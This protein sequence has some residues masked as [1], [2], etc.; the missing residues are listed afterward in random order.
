MT[1]KF[2]NPTVEYNGVTYQ[3][4]LATVDTTHIG[5]EDHGIFSLNLGFAYESGSYQGIGHLSAG[6]EGEY[7]G[8]L[9]TSIL[10]VFGGYT[11]WEALKGS[12]IYVLREEGWNGLIRGILSLDQE[13][14]LVFSDLFP[15]S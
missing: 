13:R 15:N 6:K 1:V 4:E 9:V 14:V 2:K 7:L 11:N 12:R 10:K 8:K 5:T 3:V